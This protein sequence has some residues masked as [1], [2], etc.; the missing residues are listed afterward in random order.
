MTRSTFLFLICLAVCRAQMTTGEIEGTVRDP[1]GSAIA[2]AK[3]DLR[4]LETDSSRQV[5]TDTDG[6]FRFAQVPVGSYEVNVESPGFGIY[7]QTGI[8]LRLNQIASLEIPL[9]LATVVER[10]NVV[11][12]AS[13]LNATNAELGVNFDRRRI[14]ELPLSPNRNLL[15][16]ALSVAGVTQLQAGQSTLVNV[17]GSI[18]FAV[19]GMRPRSNNFLIDG[20]D[21]SSPV[22]TGLA[23]QLNN[24]DIVAEFRLITNQ[25][26]PEFGRTAGSIV[27]IVTKSGGNE[28]HGSSFWFHNSN[29]LNARSNLD[30]QTPFRGENQWGGTLG[31]PVRR[32]KTFFFGS[33][34][35]WTDR[36]V[37]GARTLSGVPTNEGRSLLASIA[38]NRPT[39]KILLEHLPPAQTPTGAEIP[40]T[41]GDRRM[42]IPLGRLSGSSTFRYDDWQWSGR[43]DHRLNSKHTVGGRYL[44][45]DRFTS[46]N[47]QV[48]PP[49]LTTDSPQRPQA[50]SAFINSAFSSSAFHELRVAYQR[51]KGGQSSTNPESA[52]IPSIEVTEL[53]LS[54]AGSGATRTA[55]GLA[56]DLPR[57]T[58]T[59]RYQI[60]TTLGVHKGSHS[61]KFGVDLRREHVGQ[62]LEENAR[63]RLVY[64]TLQDLVDDI[65]Q[66]GQINSPLPGG[67]GRTYYRA[68]DYAFFMQD[69]WRLHPNLTLSFGV[70]YE[71]MGN[72][73][74]PFRAVSE[75]IV[76]AHGGDRRF[77]LA[78]VAP[79]D[80]NNWA[81]RLGLNYRVPKAPGLLGAL[82]GKE[83]LVL[84]AGYARTYDYAYLM[85]FGFANSFPLVKGDSLERR[86]PNS[87]EQIR[88]LAA[89]SFSGD[90][91]GLRR[92]LPAGDLRSPFAEQVLLQLQREIRRDWLVSLGYVGTKG[93]ALF[94]SLDLNPT[95]PGSQGRRANPGV[96]VRTTKCN[97]TSSTYHSLQTSLEKRLSNEFSLA[98][99]YTWS[100]FIDGASDIMGISSGEL[101][102]AQDSFNRHADR[103]RSAYDRPHR[104]A[105]NGVLELPFWRDQKRVFG[106]L[107][108]GWQASGFLT[109][110]SGAPFAVLDGGDPGL[111]LTPISTSVRANMNTHLDLARMSVEEMVRSGGTSLFSR[112]TVAS[113]L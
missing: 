4:Q 10:V 30:Q 90:A 58:I 62:L 20:Q 87:L 111:R 88:S 63:G 73:I 24:P 3:V 27:N 46:G 84:R 65:A 21:V 39:V 37:G 61:S 47:G 104:I 79:R 25:F 82:T 112:V 113:P 89:K 98:A 50:A 54:G 94:Q 59:N 97:C 16:L 53:G 44:F 72:P 43:V 9:Q 32:N 31:G 8:I 23:Q 5:L 92:E 7:V 18:P 106:K 101:G 29:R 60:Q 57:E 100:S 36:R 102:Y 26:A 110:Q 67:T 49:G 2:L 13:L 70:R 28:F 38:G 81:P 1:G 74:E 48:A 51:F 85:L 41:V 78:P 35:R 40:V 45:N 95:I 93:T 83:S 69:E 80:N 77:E 22:L 56:T 11:S 86:T 12:D 55:I 108:G 33:L 17:A 91:D 34:Q 6:R 103:G 99:H 68:S 64:E 71:S 42:N 66:L 107:L 105:V 52:R 19:N 96:G 14:A 15:T 75:R 109:L 76:A